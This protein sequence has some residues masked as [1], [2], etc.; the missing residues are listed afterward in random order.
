[1]TQS[2]SKRSDIILKILIAENLVGCF[3]ITGLSLLI[4]PFVHLRLSSK[5][6]MICQL[7]Y[8]D[9]NLMKETKHFFRLTTPEAVVRKFAV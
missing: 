5:T 6:A 3:W 8:K 7:N 9:D 1:M 2:F 4:F